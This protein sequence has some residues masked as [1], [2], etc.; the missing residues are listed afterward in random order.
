MLIFFERAAQ[1]LLPRRDTLRIVGFISLGGLLEALWVR[2]GLHQL[3]YFIGITWSLGL[4]LLIPIYL[5]TD[6]RPSWIRR[7]SEIVRSTMV[8]FTAL[9]Y[10]ILIIISISIV[11]K[12]I[13]A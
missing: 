9:W 13:I 11:I 12:L 2:E 6:H 8:F 5:S 10:V 4:T 7:A 3:L 1:R